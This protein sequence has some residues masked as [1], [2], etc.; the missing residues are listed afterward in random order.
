M[1]TTISSPEIMAW[2]S[3]DSPEIY[4]SGAFQLT[5]HNDIAFHVAEHAI[6]LRKYRGRSQTEIAREMRTS[7]SAIARIEAGDDNIT[8]ST[9]RRL[10]EALKGRIRFAIEPSEISFPRWEE[11]WNLH[12]AGLGSSSTWSFRGAEERP[13]DHERRL[14]GGWSTDVT[15][16]APKELSLGEAS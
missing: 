11:W 5:W 6:N 13:A 12:A 16:P 8:L 2:S 10:A 3:S 4:S 15:T 7:Q 1:L 9:L 14:A